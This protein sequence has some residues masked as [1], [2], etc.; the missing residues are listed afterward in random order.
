MA[1]TG[2]P[3]IGQQGYYQD[4]DLDGVVQTEKDGPLRFGKGFAARM[5]NRAALWVRVHPNPLGCAAMGTGHH[6]RFHGRLFQKLH[7]HGGM[8]PPKIVVRVCKLLP[9]FCN[10]GKFEQL[11]AILWCYRISVTWEK[12][13]H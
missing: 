13:Y 4:H 7:S 2:Q 10:G 5:A 6:L 12:F 9:H 11:H 3:T 8:P 1:A